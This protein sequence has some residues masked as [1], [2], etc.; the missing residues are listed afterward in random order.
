M[1]FAI[2]ATFSVYTLPLWVTF[3]ISA[4]KDGR[5]QRIVRLSHKR[6]NRTRRS[7]SACPKT[8]KAGKGWKRS[9][10]IAH[11]GPGEVSFLAGALSIPEDF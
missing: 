8:V 9:S 11:G 1:A 7:A 5:H 3:A 2:G 6:G 10:L 4:A